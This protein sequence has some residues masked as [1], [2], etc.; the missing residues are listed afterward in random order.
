MRLT[1]ASLS[2]TPRHELPTDDPEY[3]YQ[4]VRQKE[5]A[6]ERRGAENATADGFMYL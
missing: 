6:E 1:Y 3:D 2:L 4:R 5:E